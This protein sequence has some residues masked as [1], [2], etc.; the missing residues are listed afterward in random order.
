MLAGAIWDFQLSKT[1]FYN[2]G[3]GARLICLI[4]QGKNSDYLWRGYVNKKLNIAIVLKKIFIFVD[5]PQLE[6][7]CVKSLSK[8]IM[9]STIVLKDTWAHFVL[10][11]HKEFV[12]NIH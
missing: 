1:G 7:L 4:W 2:K 3:L 8:L 5:S 6:S 11:S 10:K 9:Q 12:Y